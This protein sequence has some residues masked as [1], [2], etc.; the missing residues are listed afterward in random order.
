MKLKS[1]GRAL[2][3]LGI[4]GIVLSG[5]IGWY[6][7]ATAKLVT[8]INPHDASVVSLNKSMYTKGDNVEEVYGNPLE[9]KVRLVML[10]E[11]KIIHPEEDPSLTLYPVDK[12]K[13]DNPIQVQ[14][15]WLFMRSC[16]GGFLIVT[17]I[18]LVLFKRK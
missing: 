3:I 8:L 11:K 13:G 12:Q 1:I 2:T 10:D 4:C 16:L 17:V 5:A 14:S 18:G 9:K 15:I 6:L 7:I